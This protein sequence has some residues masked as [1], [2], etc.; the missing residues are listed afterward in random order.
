MRLCSVR[1]NVVS[2]YPGGNRPRAQQI[3]VQCLAVE[4]EQGD[5]G[6]FRLQIVVHC[7]E[8]L[9]M[10]EERMRWGYDCCNKSSCKR[11]C[12]INIQ[13]LSKK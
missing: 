5:I 12:S 2:R 7:P 13:F 1:L 6:L 8:E 4:L 3:R 11:Y 10:E 9:W